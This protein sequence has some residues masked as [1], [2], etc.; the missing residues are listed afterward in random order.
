MRRCFFLAFLSNSVTTLS[1]ALWVN[2]C[3]AEVQ[4]AKMLRAEFVQPPKIFVRHT[5]TIEYCGPTV[6]PLTSGKLLIPGWKFESADGGRTWAQVETDPWL[7][8][9]NIIRLRNGDWAAIVF[10]PSGLGQGSSMPA[11]RFSADDAATWTD[12][13]VLAK[14][15]NIYYVMNERLIETSQRAIVVPV[16][17]GAGQYE[18]DNNVSG[19]FYSTD[20]GKTWSESETWASLEGERGM[21]EPVIAEL[22]DGRLL[23]L[24]RT[25][26]G[27]HYRSY[28]SDVGRTWS[29]AQPTTLTAACSPLTMKSMPDGRLLVVYDHS[30]PLRAEAFFPRC[31]M[32]YAV[33][34]DGGKTW[35][36]PL[37]I[38][39][40]EGQQHIYPSITF[41]EPGILIIYSS[42]YASPTGD[43]SR[44]DDAWWKIGGGKSCI[45]KYPLKF[46]VEHNNGE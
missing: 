31:P 33:S 38:D 15:S 16:A 40:E 20:G 11:I 4:P 8:S 19:C 22:A 7:G 6:V 9:N 10:E 37:L 24:A 34:S 26:K 5:D 18:G 44:P 12:R 32:V 39:D 2:Y 30:S 28:S 27:S 25:G 14:K 21:A 13:L 42:V 45:L 3:F 41:L 1:L 35:G 36:N 17:R 29:T 23:M 43:F 46:Q